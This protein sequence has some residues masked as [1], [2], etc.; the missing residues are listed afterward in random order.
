MSTVDKITA[1]EV[2]RGKYTSDRARQIVESEYAWGGVAYGVTTAHDIDIN[3]YADTHFV[4]NPRVY[5]NYK[6]DGCLK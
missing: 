1:D 6:R 3:R 2:A 5:W 4:R